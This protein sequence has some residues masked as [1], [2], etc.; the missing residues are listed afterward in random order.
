M[1]ERCFQED[2][3][4]YQWLTAYMVYISSLQIFLALADFCKM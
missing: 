4:E 3:V 1:T 2:T